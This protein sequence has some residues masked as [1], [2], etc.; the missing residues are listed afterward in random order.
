M[1]LLLL[2]AG[3]VMFGCTSERELQA[4]MVDAT[5]VNVE[6]VNRY[7]DV[8]EKILTWRTSTKV[9]YITYEPES[10]DLAIGTLRKVLIQK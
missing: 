8:R 2:L 4:H 10:T 1:K 9:T 3:A 7:P 6:L 5:L